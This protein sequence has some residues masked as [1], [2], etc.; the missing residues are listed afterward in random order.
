MFSVG[1]FLDYEGHVWKMF[2]DYAS[3]D[4]FYNYCL[5]NTKEPWRYCFVRVISGK[6]D[7]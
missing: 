4:A 5:K 6:V 3:A 1:E 7:V 2:D